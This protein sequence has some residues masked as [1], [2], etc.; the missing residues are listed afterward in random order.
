MITYENGIMQ[1]NL[2]IEQNQLGNNL[3][4]MTSSSNDPIEQATSMANNI[5]K[6]IYESVYFRSDPPLNIPD[7]Y[8]EYIWFVTP[9][10]TI[11]KTIIDFEQNREHNRITVPF[12]PRLNNQSNIRNNAK[13]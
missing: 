3:P 8:Q 5:P 7:E 11:R 6:Y 2:A 1:E 10:E 13:D 12:H 4:L 9:K